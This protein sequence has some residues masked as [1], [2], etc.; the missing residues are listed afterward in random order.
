M[1]TVQRL[2]DTLGD[3]GADRDEMALGSRGAQRAP[4]RRQR[5][6]PEVRAGAW[7]FGSTPSGYYPTMSLA[8]EA[9]WIVVATPRTVT[10]I[11]IS[12][13]RRARPR[14]GL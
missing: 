11:G 10:V 13:A 9:F 7:W 8:P 3:A 5:D 2:V 12:P 14:H 1:T 6:L 4:A